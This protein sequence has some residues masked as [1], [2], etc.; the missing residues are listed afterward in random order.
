MRTI[1]LQV[2]TALTLVVASGPFD[3]RAA[4]THGLEP[5]SGSFV[6]E[7]TEGVDR[8]P[9][10][11]KLRGLGGH[12][13][14]EYR[15]L[16]RRL[17]V[18]GVPAAAEQALARL[19]GVIS[20]TPDY[21]LHAHLAESVPLIGA[22][23]AVPGTGGGAGINVC[24]L[25]TGIDPGHIMFSDT[26]SRIL[27]WRDFVNGS[28]EPYDNHGHGSHVAGVL[29]GR[30]GV[31]F[32]DDPFHGV[33]FAATL[34]IGKVLTASGSGSSSDVIAA[35]DWCAS[36]VNADVINLSLGGGGFS[37]PCDQLDVSGTAQ[38]VNAAAAAGILVVASSGNDGFVN[39]TS[40]PACA[41]GSMA[42]GATYDADVGRTLFG[43]CQDRKTRPDQI[44]CF[45][46]G[47]DFLDVVAP[48]CITYSTNAGTSAGV[49]GLCG[50]SQAAPHVSGL[51]A[52]IMAANPALTAAETRQCIN[53]TA[54]DLGDPGFD[55]TFGNGR[56]RAAQAVACDLGCAPTEA[57]E[58]SCEDGLDNDCD[59]LPDAADPDCSVAPVCGANKAACSGNA[60]CCSGNCNRGRCRGN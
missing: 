27:A 57:S 18:R 8:G 36:T 52:L 26:P 11:A 38:A 9:F 20:V 51:A 44:A 48:G 22:E 43:E 33:A 32:G 3:A 30:D 23:P 58:V 45:S 5:V 59:G 14:Y 15:L 25:D 35:I 24:V 13:R 29:G 60:D 2:L 56:I 4:E 49:L 16:P 37:K 40:T 42:V 55:R 1:P 17:N 46:N 19:P 28:P 10:R 6:V 54:R 39:A 31:V 21:V 7:L 50:T 41:S 12:V 34:S 53:S 47:A